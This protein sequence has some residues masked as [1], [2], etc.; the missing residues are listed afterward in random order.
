MLPVSRSIRKFGIPALFACLLCIG[1]AFAA[2]DGTSSSEPS[3]ETVGGK[4]Y[5]LI[6]N[7]ANLKWFADQVK[8]WADLSKRAQAAAK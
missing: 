1:N 2:W 7:E 4:T 8:L 3:T 5:Y 6:A